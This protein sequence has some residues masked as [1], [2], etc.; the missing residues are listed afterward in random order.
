MKPVQIKKVD[1]PLIADPANW[2]LFGLDPAKGLGIIGNIGVGKTL[3]MNKLLDNLY[4]RPLTGKVYDGIRI[5]QMILKPGWEK[6]YANYNSLKHTYLLID[7]LA[8][9]GKTRFYDSVNPA[10]DLLNLRYNL[11]Q[12]IDQKKLV[13]WD[14]SASFNYF[15]C[16]YNL[17]TLAEELGPDT[18]DRLHEM[19]N[20]VYVGGTSYRSGN[21]NGQIN[22]TI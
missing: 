16:N 12:T 14:A 11:W 4:F 7:D 9:K 22:A 17:E 3:T 13:P 1:L 18:V 21:L 5:S 15:T 6:T 19:C 20:F 10:A 8:A 2:N